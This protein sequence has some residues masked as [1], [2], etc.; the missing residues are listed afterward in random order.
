VLLKEVAIQQMLSY[1]MGKNTP[2]RQ[3][4]IINRL[5]IE[6]DIVFE[7]ETTEVEEV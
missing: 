6:K 5:R 7:E 4:F 3:D 1:F 2:E